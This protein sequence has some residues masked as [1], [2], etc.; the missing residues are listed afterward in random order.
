[1]TK[2]YKIGVIPGS[3][4]IPLTDS[5]T[6][7]TPETVNLRLPPI[8]VTLRK[9]Q[10]FVGKALLIHCGGP[11]NPNNNHSTTLGF[12]DLA[13][14][15]FLAV[16][17]SE[18]V[19][20]GCLD[21]KKSKMIKYDSQLSTEP[22]YPV[23]I[24]PAPAGELDW[25]P[26]VQNTNEDN[27]APT[28]QSKTVSDISAEATVSPSIIPARRSKRHRTNDAKLILDFANSKSNS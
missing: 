4:I 9:H 2:N 25:V 11:S 16:R 5:L 7:N 18:H 14:H 12:T 15:V 6:F 1:M 10:I 17:P 27:N 3:H 22:T 19:R 8:I 20:D 28:S 21:P 23:T 13:L 26:S 24:V